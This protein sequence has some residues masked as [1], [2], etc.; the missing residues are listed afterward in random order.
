MKKIKLHNKNSELSKHHKNKLGYDVPQDY[1]Q[2]SKQQIMKAVTSQEETKSGFTRWKYTMMYAVAATVLLL[3]SI[4]VFR[5][6]QNSNSI[7][8]LDWA[9]Y[10]NM[11][12]EDVLF[13]TLFINDSQVDT[14]L[15]NYLGEVIIQAELQEQAFDNLFIN[16]LLQDESEVETFIDEQFLDKIVL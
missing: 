14:Y 15:D 8:T 10:E 12:D 1:F 3:L 7:Q 11:N 5:Y 6:F 13:N 2:Q 9:T 4:G 16:T